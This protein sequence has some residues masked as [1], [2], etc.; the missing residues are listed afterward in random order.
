M[1]PWWMLW[2]KHLHGNICVSLEMECLPLIKDPHLA[3]YIFPNIF[4]VF[5]GGSWKYKENILPTASILSLLQ[6]NLLKY[7]QIFSFAF[8]KEGKKVLVFMTSLL[9]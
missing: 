1:K 2:E 4:L 7:C 5:E 9:C 8:W 3:L 6:Q